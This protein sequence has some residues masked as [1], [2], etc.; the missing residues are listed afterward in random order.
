MAGT[1]S[2]TTVLSVRLA[3]DLYKGIQAMAIEE[4]R[5]IS[6]VIRVLIREALDARG[7]KKGKGGNG[8]K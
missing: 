7:H 1:S 5:E 8:R 2:I 4:D 6:E 3:N